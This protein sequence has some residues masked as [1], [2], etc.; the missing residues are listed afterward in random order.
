MD[1]LKEKG[2]MSYLDQ[3]KF[4]FSGGISCNL[5]LMLEVFL[6]KN[7]G[8]VKMSQCLDKS[9]FLTYILCFYPLLYSSKLFL[10]IF[11]SYFVSFDA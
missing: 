9:N 10:T 5:C 1:E 6:A 2:M 4:N 3:T 11:I 8:L 7:K